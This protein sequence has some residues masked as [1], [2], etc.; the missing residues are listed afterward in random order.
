MNPINIRTAAGLLVSLLLCTLPTLAHAKQDP[1]PPSIENTKAGVSD[2]Q[3]NFLWEWNVFFGAAPSLSHFV[4]IDLCD[5]VFEDIVPQSFFGSPSTEWGLDPTTGETGLKFDDIEGDD[6]ESGLFGFKTENEWCAGP[7]DV[8]FKSGRDSIVYQTTT[9][10]ICDPC[11]RCQPCE[12]PAQTPEPA[13]M[14]LLGMGG[15]PLLAKFRRR[16]A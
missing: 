3:G 13:T 15:L 4:V 12:P 1:V 9:G 10:P 2:G 16:K 7:I 5:E 6:N 8:V 11:E 14:A